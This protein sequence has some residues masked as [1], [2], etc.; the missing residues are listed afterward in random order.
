[1]LKISNFGPIS[2]HF[3]K[4]LLLSNFSARFWANLEKNK[5]LPGPILK[6]KLLIKKN[7][8]SSLVSCIVHA[9]FFNNNDNLPHP[10]KW[11][12]MSMSQVMFFLKFS[13]TMLRDIFNFDFF[14]TWNMWT[15]S[16]KFFDFRAN[17]FLNYVG[18]KIVCV[19]E[20]WGVFEGVFEEGYSRGY[21]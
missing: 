21:P 15:F 1:M 4:Q 19:C 16:R 3:A 20:C 2:A 7:T 10:L 5:Q 12:W 9:Y 6:K 18:K 8:V 11:S 14:S 17:L 13:L